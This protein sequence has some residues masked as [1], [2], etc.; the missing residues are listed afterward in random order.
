MQL[1]PIS[2]FKIKI[3]YFDED[4]ASCDEVYNFANSGSA[5]YF[6]QAFGTRLLAGQEPT[7]FKSL[8]QVL[9]K[10]AY[11]TAPDFVI[12]R[13]MN[14]NKRGP[15]KVEKKLFDY[16]GNYRKANQMKLST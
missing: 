12:A 16:E 14:K 13:K 2:E 4:G 6:N 11:F 5:Y 7:Y 1:E 15:W 8:S 3:T 10:K 9:D